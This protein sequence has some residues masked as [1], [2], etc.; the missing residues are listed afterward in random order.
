MNKTFATVATPHRALMGH[1]F[2]PYTLPFDG[3]QGSR[4]NLP[5]PVQL[6]AIAV[7]PLHTSCWTIA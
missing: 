3:L 5:W 1:S 7:D 4:L 2:L 6:P